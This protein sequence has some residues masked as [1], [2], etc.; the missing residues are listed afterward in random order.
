MTDLRVYWCAYDWAGHVS[1]PGTW[2]ASLLPELRRRGIDSVVNT[3]VWDSSGPLVESLRGNQ[4]ETLVHPV[5]GT[6]QERIRTVITGYEQSNADIFV[7][8]HVVPA[9]VAAKWIQQIGVPALAV[10]HSDDAFYRGV[11]DVFL[12][13]RSQDRVGNAVAVSQCLQQLAVQTGADRNCIHHLPYGVHVPSERPRRSNCSG[14][15]LAFSGRMV[16]EQKRVLDVAHVMQRCVTEVEGCSGVLIGDGAE[17]AAVAD[18]LQNQIIAGRI[19]LTGRLIPADVQ[20]RLSTADILLLLSDYEGLP[21]A[22]LEAMACGL[23]PVVSRMRSGIPELVE[24]M[25][26]GIVVEDRLESVLKSVRML[27]SDAELLQ[28]LSMA[29]RTTVL[30][31]FSHQRCA[32]GWEALLRQMHSARRARE[33]RVTVPRRFDLPP[34]HPALAAEDPRG[35][36]LTIAE[37]VLGTGRRFLKRFAGNSLEMTDNG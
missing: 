19:E 35:R 15:K 26:N 5:A 25:V 29:A 6:T 7:A 36:D 30:E 21:I 17:F 31:R 27:N 32:D 3:L 14:V 33:Q 13:G 12:A 16:Q 28:R 10:L 37:S 22:L 23:V 18:L 2:L 8:N 24:H 11:I 4:I 1:G 20:D 34:I 9:L